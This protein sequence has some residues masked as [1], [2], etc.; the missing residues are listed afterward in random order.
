MNRMEINFANWICTC[1]APVCTLAE[2]AIVCS[3][4]TRKGVV[5]VEPGIGSLQ[6]MFFHLAGQ[7]PNS[8]FPH[9]KQ[10][11]NASS[12]KHTQ[13]RIHRCPCVEFADGAWIQTP[14]LHS[15]RKGLLSPSSTC[16]ISP[17]LHFLSITPPGRWSVL[18]FS[19][20]HL[21]FEKR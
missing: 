15:R 19:L 10:S 21:K 2:I 7:S 16:R 3:W 13:I 14:R 9:Q 11:W 18:K 6:Q 12:A 1:I 20:T 5:Q 17:S 4:A 8:S